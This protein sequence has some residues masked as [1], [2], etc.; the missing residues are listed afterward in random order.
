MMRIGR[1]GQWRW[2]GM[3]ETAMQGVETEGG[4]EVQTRYALNREQIS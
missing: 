2:Q 3:A 4:G 1:G